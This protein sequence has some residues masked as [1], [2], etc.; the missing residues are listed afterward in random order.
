[1]QK[2]TQGIQFN[3]ILKKQGEGEGETS[4][5][6]SPYR[7]VYKSSQIK[8]FYQF[9]ETNY[10]F[11]PFDDFPCIGFFS[12]DQDLKKSK[13]TSPYKLAYLRRSPAQ[14]F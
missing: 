5:L 10:R 3:S 14:P 2:K 4:N 8:P 12:A 11:L 13:K 6:L 7:P 1:M 9:P